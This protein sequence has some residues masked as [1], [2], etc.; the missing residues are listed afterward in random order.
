MKKTC[1]IL[2]FICFSWCSLLGQNVYY[3]SRKIK[4]LFE[5]SQQNCGGNAVEKAR[6]I[7]AQKDAIKNLYGILQY[8]LPD[9]LKNV[10]DL[11]KIKAYFKSK[12]EFLKDFLPEIT[13]QEGEKANSIFLRGITSASNLDVTS[14]ADGLAR[15]LIKRGKEELNIAFFQ[16]M[17]N[18]LDSSVEAKTLFPATSKFLENIEPYRY[19]EFLLSLR[20]VF[21]ADVSNLIVNLNRLIDLPKYKDL[22]KALPEIRVSVRSAMIISE[23]SQ[24]DSSLHPANL[25]SHFAVLKEWGEMNINLHSSWR[26]LDEISKSIRR[27]PYTMERVYIDSSK[28]SDSPLGKRD[29]FLIIT[30]V[31]DDISKDDTLPMHKNDTFGVIRNT[32][33][34]GIR[35]ENFT[36]DPNIPAWIRFSDFN[37][38]I[39]QDS[40]TLKIFLGLLYQ[41]M[42]GIY[43][44]S[45]SDSVVS[46]QEFMRINRPYIFRISGLVENF[47]VLANDVEQS[48]HD[49]RNKKD[50]LT[51]DD[52]Y[53]YIEKAINIVDYGFKVANTINDGIIDDRYIA[54]ARNANNLYKNIYT[55]NYNAAVM[56]AYLVL[57]EIMSKSKEAV[58]E[59]NAFFTALAKSGSNLS[60]LP[61]KSQILADTANFNSLKTEL[62]NFNESKAI[63]D[64][65]KVVEKLLKYGNV[66]AA[67]VK[68]DSPEEAEAA[69]EAAALPAGSSS[70]KKNSSINISLN[71]YIGGYFGQQ[72]QHK[73]DFDGN[74]SKVGV[75]APVGVAFSK[76][77]GHF[78]NGYSLGAISLYLTVI[79]VGA[80]AGFRLNNDSTA[81]EQKVTLGDIF[82]PGG[83]VVYGLGLPFLAYVPLSIGYGWQYGSRLYNKEGGKISVSTN[84]RWRSNWFVGIDI[85]LANFW[86][87]NY[88]R[89]H[90]K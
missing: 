30:T 20:E 59:K 85:P 63:L 36:S 78:K 74:N 72:F 37:K 8:Y 7:A 13:Q 55:K 23:V 79:D 2:L 45:K 11:S 90:S 69:I 31:L 62:S 46:V 61:A 80:I 33:L 38:N 65:T 56:N 41:K 70:I 15:F 34:T 47:L 10:S 54:M 6:C 83:Y 14:L 21:Y 67:I 28:T 42:D 51:D 58:S 18:F 40:I 86:T 39:L 9:S 77:L 16:Q 50:R 82:T 35:S 57:Q 27:G 22:L 68:A 29:T 75:T 17:K 49:L 89:A 5:I 66:M 3:D 25:I 12:N 81:L 48:V 52:Y 88:Q 26:V 43:F 73:Q 53:T 84:S 1:F 44:L 76:G 24:R 60:L 19:S 87:R 64:R 71:A 4:E 32:S